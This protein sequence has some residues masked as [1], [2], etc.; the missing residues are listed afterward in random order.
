M[1]RG[2]PRCESRA[3]TARCPAPRPARA[4]DLDR[5]V[6]VVLAVVRQVD[7][8]HAAAADL[9]IDFVAARERGPSA[10]HRSVTAAPTPG[11]PASG[12]GTVWYRL[13]YR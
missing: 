5:H 10:L 3:G 6:A 13:D 12:S 4:E 8:R 1:L 9:A 11:R 7:A 2:G